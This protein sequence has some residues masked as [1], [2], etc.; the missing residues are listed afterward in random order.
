MVPEPAYL[1]YDGRPSHGQARVPG[2]QRARAQLVRARPEVRDVTRT[3]KARFAPHWHCW[4]D[5]RACRKK[6]PGCCWRHGPF[7]QAI[8]S[9]GFAASFSAVAVADL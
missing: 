8:R 1:E 6:G 3:L 5:H 9:A 4:I 7:Q 2:G